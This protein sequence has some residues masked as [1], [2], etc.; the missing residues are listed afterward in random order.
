MHNNDIILFKKSGTY[1]YMNSEQQ[2]FWTFFVTTI[3]GFL[4]ALGRQ[5]YKS[6]CKEVS[7]GCIKIVRD[8]ES[9]IELDE[10]RDQNQKEELKY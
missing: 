2:I 1:V 9:E 8:V 4:L 6:K 5:M 10:I 3:C 7:C